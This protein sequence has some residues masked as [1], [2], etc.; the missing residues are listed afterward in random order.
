MADVRLKMVGPLMRGLD[1]DLADAVAD[2]IIADNPDS[3]VQVHDEG[4][5]VRIQ[6]PEYCRLTQLSLERE[7]GR[8]FPLVELEPALSG[9]A[10]RMKQVNDEEI[11]WFLERKD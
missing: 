5:Y 4:G 11:V 2:A 8:A 7:L 6:V 3:D 10:G 1:M 9:F